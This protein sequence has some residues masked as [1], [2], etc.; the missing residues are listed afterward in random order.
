MSTD[1]QRVEVPPL[2]VGP[3]RHGEKI[4]E[5]QRRDSPWPWIRVRLSSGVTVRVAGETVES[6]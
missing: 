3:P 6:R 1:R 5:V 4:G 2:G